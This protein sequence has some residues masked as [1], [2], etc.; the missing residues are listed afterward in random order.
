MQYSFSP[1]PFSPGT[2]LR[3]GSISAPIERSAHGLAFATLPNT[4]YS[5]VLNRYG[6]I[7]GCTTPGAMRLASYM[8]GQL[9]PSAGVYIPEWDPQTHRSILN[10]WP[11]S[12]G[13]QGLACSG[14]I[15]APEETGAMF[16][17]SLLG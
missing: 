3:I 8:P 11:P 13:S 12:I 5:L 4:A 7:T 10:N 9:T 1:P 16:G 2:M 15:H 17:Q 14:G 6:G